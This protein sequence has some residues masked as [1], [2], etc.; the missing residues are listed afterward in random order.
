MGESAKSILPHLYAPDIT[1]RIGIEEQVPR[2]GLS[3][4]LFCNSYMFV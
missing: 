4:A 1:T 2:E 3:I